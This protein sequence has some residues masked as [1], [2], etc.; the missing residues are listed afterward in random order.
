MVSPPANFSADPLDRSAVGQNLQRLAAIIEYSDDAL[1]TK[2]LSGIVT[3]WNRG[4]ERL[5]GYPSGEMIGQPVMAL[6]TA[7][8]EEDSGPGPEENLKHRQT[9]SG[10]AFNSCLC[11]RSI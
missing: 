9:F 11:K 6:I 8:K 10:F 4:A 2:D 1:L 5:F 7:A 3:S